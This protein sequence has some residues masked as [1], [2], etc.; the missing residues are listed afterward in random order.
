MSPSKCGVRVHHSFSSSIVSIVST[1]LSNLPDYWACYSFNS[2]LEGP[3]TLQKLVVVRALYE[4]TY[5]VVHCSII[6]IVPPIPRLLKPTVM[7]GLR[8]VARR[9]FSTLFIREVLEK[10]SKILAAIDCKHKE[11]RPDDNVL[12]VLR[13]TYH[14]H[15]RS[16]LSVPIM[17]K[18]KPLVKL[19]E[20]C[21]VQGST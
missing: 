1:T 11:K 17:P 19:L 14:L 20:C 10:T 15:G 2:C 13:K 5:K 3:S 6:Q 8:Q 4:C 12:G 21:I 9:H 7:D 16:P 18:S